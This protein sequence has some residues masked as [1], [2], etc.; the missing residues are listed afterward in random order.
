MGKEQ[1]M[2]GCEGSSVRATVLLLICCCF[3]TNRATRWFVLSDAW[4][5]CGDAVYFESYYKEPLVEFTRTQQLSD[6]EVLSGESLPD[7]LIRVGVIGASRKGR[8]LFFRLAPTS[9]LADDAGRDFVYALDRNGGA[10]GE[11]MARS[12]GRSF[13]YHI[14]Y[15]KTPGWYYWMHN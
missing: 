8:F 6:G 7:S 4:S 1:C 13:T 3:V 10:V 5:E 14:Q 2:K 15:L 12:A 9:I 11:L